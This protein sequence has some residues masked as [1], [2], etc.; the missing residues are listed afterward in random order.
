MLT[1]YIKFSIIFYL[2]FITSSAMACSCRYISTETVAYMSNYSLS[3]LE[4]KSP[5]IIERLA[6][7]NI[8]NGDIKRVKVKVI[9]DIKG[10]YEQKFLDINT[11][12]YIGEC[13]VTIEY[14]QQVY[15]IN[16]KNKNGQWSHSISACNIVGKNF[17][18]A[19]KA[20]IS[21]K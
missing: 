12:D 2:M 18:E 6:S 19:V 15:L 13:G 14:G 3:K 20:Q 5:S 9:E 8:F 1:I 11:N 10:T 7:F 4:I 17:A 16:T 21:I